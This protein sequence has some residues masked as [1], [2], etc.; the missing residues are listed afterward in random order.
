[1]LRDWFSTLPAYD[2]NAASTLSALIEDCQRESLTGLL[3]LEHSSGKL[4]L[5]TFVNGKGI[6]LFEYENDKWLSIPKSEW[7]TK[8]EGSQT[9]IRKSHMPVQ[10]V[11]SCE[12][13]L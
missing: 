8:L 2:R 7:M 3:R 1:M 10:G 9:K 13:I 11:R 12:V 6:S 4:F 5:W